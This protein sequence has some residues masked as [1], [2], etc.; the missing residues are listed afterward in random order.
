MKSAIAC[1]T[2][3]SV[4]LAIG[5]MVIFPYQC[6]KGETKRKP[7]LVQADAKQ[8]TPE[9]KTNSVICSGVSENGV[10]PHSLTYL[11]VDVPPEG[12]WLETHVFMRAGYNPAIADGAWAECPLNLYNHQYDYLECEVPSMG[13]LGKQVELQYLKTEVDDA[14]N[15]T[16]Y[17]VYA[18]TNSDHAVGVGKLV[19]KYSMPGSVCTARQTFN[20]NAGSVATMILLLPPGDI[21]VGWRTFGRELLGP[22]YKWH[23]CDDSYA[24]IVNRCL[25]AEGFTLLDT[26]EGQDNAVGRFNQCGD[27]TSNRLGCRIELYYAPGLRVP[28]ATDQELPHRLPN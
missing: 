10:G 1:R 25:P 8:E 11:A 24:G 4:L 28:T 2:G 12:T 6:S 21:V 19:V 26:R 15:G 17:S 7:S 5:A 23:V 3:L 18:H 14:D 13:L 9:K 16:R 22:T 27:G 20:A